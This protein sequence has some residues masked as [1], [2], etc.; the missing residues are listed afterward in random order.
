MLPSASSYN[1]F[2]GAPGAYSDR[3]D[4][5][6][7]DCKLQAEFPLWGMVKATTYVQINNLFNRILNTRTYDWGSGDLGTDGSGMISAPIPGRPIAAF[8]MPWGYKGDS[9]YWLN[10][11]TF[12]QFAFGLKF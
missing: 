6:T 10:G 8:N 11:R 9:S 12:A 5:Y 7:I 4:V 2:Y 3:T 1:A